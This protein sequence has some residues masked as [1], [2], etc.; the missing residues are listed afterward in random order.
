MIYIYIHISH[1][2]Y[3]NINFDN[4]LLLNISSSVQNEEPASFKWQINALI[5][6]IKDK[7]L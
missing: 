3:Y 7:I 4:T 1:E 2:Y 6:K 5:L